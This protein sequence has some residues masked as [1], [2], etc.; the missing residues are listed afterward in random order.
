MA[1]AFLA[2]G[3]AT[4]SGNN[5]ICE[6]P[7]ATGRY[8]LQGVPPGDY[9]VSL[10]A[11]GHRPRI[12]NPGEPIHLT[13][14]DV[15]LADAEL[16]EGGAQITGVV[17]DA[18]GGPIVGAR[19]RATFSSNELPPGRFLSAVTKS[20]E[21]GS[22]ALTVEEGH[23]LLVAAADGYADDRMGT[24]APIQ[25]I[26][27]ALTPASRISGTVVTQSDRTPVEGIRVIAHGVAAGTVTISAQIPE[28][29][30]SV[31]REL[32]PAQDVND[33]ELRIRSTASVQN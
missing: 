27:L 17:S 8:D 28:G 25:G 29:L 5:P 6:A 26:H 4:G 23:V 21:A 20:G 11:N 22:F 3:D 9:Q 16:D 1:C 30:V 19:V 10:T 32:A 13:N 24:R 18:T 15:E 2:E 31:V 14:K 33:I 7:D 12:A